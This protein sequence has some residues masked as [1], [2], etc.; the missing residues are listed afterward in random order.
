MKFILCFTCAQYKLTLLF[1]ILCPGVIFVGPGVILNFV[2]PNICL[3]GQLFDLSSV[4]VCP[5]FVLF[6]Y[7]P[8][9]LNLKGID[10]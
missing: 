1:Y 4:I 9:K 2:C 8:A 10:S 3:P 7:S 5:A 6:Y